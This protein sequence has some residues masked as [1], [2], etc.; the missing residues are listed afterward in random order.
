MVAVR[1]VTSEL[2]VLIAPPLPVALAPET[3]SPESVTVEP[4]N[5]NAEVPRPAALITDD[6]LPVPTILNDPALAFTTASEP[7]LV[8][9]LL[10]TSVRVAEG[11]LSVIPIPLATSGFTAA[12]AVRSVHAPLADVEPGSIAVET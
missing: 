3:V 6:A 10:G 12:T 9:L 2:S 11:R 1:S 4:V 5:V 8:P 7:V